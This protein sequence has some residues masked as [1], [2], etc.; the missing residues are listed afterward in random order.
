MNLIT[1]ITFGNIQNLFRISIKPNS[2]LPLM[3]FLSMMSIEWLM[4]IWRQRALVCRRNL[5]ISDSHKGIVSYGNK[6]LINNQINRATL[7]I[8]PVPTSGSSAKFLI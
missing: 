4:G 3:I 7:M 8:L 6:T 1:G 5:L 2:A